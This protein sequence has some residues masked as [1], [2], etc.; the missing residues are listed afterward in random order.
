MQRFFLVLSVSV[1]VLAAAAGFYT[2]EGYSNQP[3]DPGTPPTEWP[4]RSKIEIVSPYTL[5][6]FLHPLCPCSKASV[7]EL[8]RLVAKNPTLRAVAVFTTPP[9]MPPIEDRSL[10]ESVH[11]IPGVV[12][13]ND[14][15]GDEAELFGSK[16]SGHVLLFNDKGKR[17]FTGGITA[18]RGHEGD[19]IGANAITEIVTLKHEST[20]A[21]TK[22]FGCHLQNKKTLASK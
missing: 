20:V 12:A 5:V 14:P 6:M 3:S 22:M 19:S 16:T 21:E 11:A 7:S 9:D 4:Q 2:L 17:L 10:I 13:V 1:W 18:S 8:K 15:K